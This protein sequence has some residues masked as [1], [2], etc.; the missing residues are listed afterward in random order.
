M[1]ECVHSAARKR[2]LRERDESARRDLSP[3]RGWRWWWL[4][5]SETGG[6]ARKQ[7]ARE[8]CAHRNNFSVIPNAAA[9][10]RPPPPGP[11][12]RGRRRARLLRLGP[13]THRGTA[14]AVIAGVVVEHRRSPAPRRQCLHRRRVRRA[15]QWGSGEFFLFV[16]AHTYG[17]GSCAAARMARKGAKDERDGAR[18]DDGA[19]APGADGDG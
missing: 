7:T 12:S 11:H 2:E 19:H 8:R 13:F 15:R 16:R 10:R 6:V 17:G 4:R 9:H 3:A 1:R 5:E 14:A 18:R